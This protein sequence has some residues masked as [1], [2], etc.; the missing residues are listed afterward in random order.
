[1]NRWTRAVTVAS[2]AALALVVAPASR[3]QGSLVPVRIIAF[4][5]FHG[6]L[7]AG[8]ERRGIAGSVRSVAQDG[9]CAPAAPRTWRRSSRGCARNNRSTSSC[10]AATSSAPRR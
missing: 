8:R 10:R 1:M 7:E 2:I 9:G 3:S 4:N 6:H 5:D